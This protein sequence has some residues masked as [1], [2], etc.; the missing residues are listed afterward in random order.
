MSTFRFSIF[1]AAILLLNACERQQEAAATPPVDPQAESPAQAEPTASTG[2]TAVYRAPDLSGLQSGEAMA[3]ACASEVASLKE[4]LGLLERFEGI[5]TV[6]N[7][8]EPYNAVLVSATNMAFTAGSLAGVSPDEGVRKAADDCSQSLTSVFSD[9]SLSRPL[10]ERVSQVELATADA[11]TQRFVEK[12]LRAFHLSGVDKDDATRTRIKA[13]NEELTVVGQEFDNNIRD[14]VSYLELDSV[15]QLD[16]LPQDYVDAHPPGEDGKIRISTQYPDLTPFMTYA[17]SDDLRHQLSLLRNNLAYPQNQAVL[18]KLLALRFEL[19]RL[20]GF[21]NY[22][23]WVTADKMVGSPQRVEGF[24]EELKGYTVESQGREYAMLLARLQQD[25]PGAEKVESWQASYLQEKVKA[26]QYDV[27]AKAVREYFSYNQ[28]R[29]GIFLLMQDLFNVQIKPWQTYTWD[30]SVEAYELWDGDQLIGS[31]FLDMHPRPNKYQHAAQFPLRNGISGVQ[32]PLSALVCNFPSGDG[33]MEHGDV[34]TFLHEFGHLMHTMLSGGHHWADIA[35]ISTEW[36][37]VEAPSQMLEEWV[38]DYDTLSQFAKNAA[39]EPIPKTLLD[40]MIAARDF[41]LGLDTRRQ[42]SLAAISMGL[43]NRDPQGLDIK[44]F[45]D[46]I[47]R[48]FSPFEPLENGHFYAAFGH[49]NGYSAIYYTYQ[50]SLAIA[51][52]MFTRFRQEGLR[53]VETAGEYRD[54]VLGQGGAKPA[55]ELVEDFLGREISF[56]P[57]ADRLRAGGQPAIEGQ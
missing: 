21:E 1:L 22:A 12:Q 54:R 40:R 55:A 42:L 26:E 13:L 47:T 14:S 33:L 36:D 10:Y 24:L 50:W 37:F 23:E 27:D 31:F 16:G 11:G 34:E 17:K 52:D 15:D 46:G 48:E 43:H 3:A 30:E 2:L 32:T 9:Y 7:Y 19:A 57:Y 41:T 51:S 39:G 8:L 25:K 49:L 56:K 5:P 44:A 18:E 28:T 45:A 53:N 6:E 35:G 4:W 29:D 38:W 20:L